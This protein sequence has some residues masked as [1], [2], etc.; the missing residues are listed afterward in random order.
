MSGSETV[1]IS[2]IFPNGDTYEGECKRNETGVLERSGTGIHKT[3]NGIVYTGQW[4]HDKMNGTGR[5]D[6][7][8]GAVYEGNFKENMFHGTGT[9]TFPNGTKYC[10]N[11]D[12]NKLEG[13]ADFI[14]TQG[15]VWRGTF[16]YTAAP[17]LKLK[18]EM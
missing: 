17:G 3:P 9:Y 10:G 15:L 14:D 5:L 6:H 18:L 11:F 12:E 13:E 1:T 7:P 4:K 8:S 16:H 2:F